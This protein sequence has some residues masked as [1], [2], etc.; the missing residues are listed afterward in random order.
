M[1][2]YSSGMNGK[3]KPF[4]TEQVIMFARIANDL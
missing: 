2:L 4:R 1:E 3:A